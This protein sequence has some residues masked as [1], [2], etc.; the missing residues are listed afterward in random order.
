MCTDALDIGGLKKCQEA[1]RKGGKAWIA[2]C[3]RILDQR[4]RA[5]CFG[6]ELLGRVACMNWCYWYY[7]EE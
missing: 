4:L 6:V 2:F 3:N 5:G 1:C 7:G